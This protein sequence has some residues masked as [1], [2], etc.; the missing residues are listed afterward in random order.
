MKGAN[1]PP[2]VKNGTCTSRVSNDFFPLCREPSANNARIF[3]LGDRDEKSLFG[4]CGPPALWFIQW[5]RTTYCSRIL[6]HN[7]QVFKAKISRLEHPPP[8][9]PV[10]QCPCLRNLSATQPCN[11]SQILVPTRASYHATIRN[12]GCMV[13]EVSARGVTALLCR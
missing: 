9:P 1:I 12:M 3:T 6:C 13:F 7:R 5:F 4:G 8:D 10:L 11:E 2:H